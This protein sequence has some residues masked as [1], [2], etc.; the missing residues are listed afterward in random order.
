M[1]K[2][3][4][5]WSAANFSKNAAKAGR[6]LI[7]IPVD[8]A[9]RI[10]IFYTY[11]ISN[12]DLVAIHT[13]VYAH[14]VVACWKWTEFFEADFLQMVEKY[15]S[16][17]LTKTD[18]WPVEVHDTYEDEYVSVARYILAADESD[19]IT[20]LDGDCFNLR[21]DNLAIAKETPLIATAHS[22]IDLSGVVLGKRPLH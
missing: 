4:K 7:E 22:T 10:T 21:R 18:D 13:P 20:Y 9:G 14:D 15:C 19:K 2:I 16:T 8:A 11:P 3:Q 6:T 17:F 5:P 1:S 12:E